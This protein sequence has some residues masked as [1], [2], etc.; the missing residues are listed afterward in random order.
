M[1]R[2]L[3]MPHALWKEMLNIIKDRLRKGRIDKPIVFALYSK[4]DNHHEIV[5]YREIP[6]V[7][8][9]GD[10]PD[11]EYDY[12]YPGIRD[13]DFYL[14][15]GTGKWFSGTLVFGDG[16]DL[17]EQDKRMMVSRDQ[18]DFRIKMDRDPTGEWSYKAYCIDF[19]AASLDLF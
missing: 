6:T 5:E 15:K 2:T 1:V 12:S 3:E 14:P 19:P 4:E 8:V 10:Y 18:M 7:K 9:T 11:G 16:T 13:L 17:D